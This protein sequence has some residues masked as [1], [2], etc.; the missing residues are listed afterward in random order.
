MRAHVRISH[1]W[2]EPRGTTICGRHPACLAGAAMSLHTPLSKPAVLCPTGMP[3]PGPHEARLLWT[4]SGMWGTPVLNDKK[5]GW[6]SCCS[7]SCVSEPY[8]E[9]FLPRAPDSPPWRGRGRRMSRFISTRSSSS[10]SYGSRTKRTEKEIDKFPEIFNTHGFLLWAVNKIDC[11]FFSK[12]KKQKTK[13]VHELF[14]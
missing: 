11:L 4:A 12:K 9:V 10:W 1:S 8:A 13:T 5:S 7:P 2:D 6:C 3:P 14:R